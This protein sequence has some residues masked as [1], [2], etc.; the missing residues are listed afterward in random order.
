MLT[1]REKHQMSQVRKVLHDN[2]YNLD[3]I[4][5]IKKEGWDIRIK[6]YSIVNFY[7]GISV[8]NRIFKDRIKITHIKTDYTGG[9]T[10]E[11][12]FNN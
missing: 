8:V 7:Q 12:Y 10:I 5:I 9:K 11:L 4:E 3:K 2:G 1:S 6:D